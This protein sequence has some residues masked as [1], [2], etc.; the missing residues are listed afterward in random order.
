[1]CALPKQGRLQNVE[2]QT[3]DTHS[4]I[5]GSSAEA[6]QRTGATSEICLAEQENE[7]SIVDETNREHFCSSK[8][9]AALSTATGAVEIP[10]KVS[11][12]TLVVRAIESR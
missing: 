1:M 8:M 11:E 5:F 6:L 12:S 3:C 7:R 10:E 4:T 9:S 2:Q